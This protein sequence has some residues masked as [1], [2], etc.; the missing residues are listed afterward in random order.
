MPLSSIAIDCRYI[1]KSILLDCS[2]GNKV[3]IINTNSKLPR[4]SPFMHNISGSKVAII[5]INSK[6]V[7]DNLL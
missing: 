2:S 5:N 1:K 6:L 3:A 7:T 4:D